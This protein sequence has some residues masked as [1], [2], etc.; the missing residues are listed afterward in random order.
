M[1]TRPELIFA[2]EPTGN[3]DSTLGHRAARATPAPP[4]DG[5]GQTVVMV[6][7]DPR[8][9]AT[10]TGSCSS[11]TA[12]SCDEIDAPTMDGDP[13]HARSGSGLSD[14]MFAPR[15]EEHARQEAAAAS[16]PA[17]AVMLGIAFLAGTLVFTDT[18]KRTFDDLFADIYAD[19][20]TVVR[21]ST[22]ISMEFGWRRPRPHPRVDRGRRS[23]DV[24]GVADAAR[25]RAGLRP[26][27]RRRRRRH[28]QPRPGRP[29]VRH[30][31]RRRRAEPVAAHRGQPRA[32]PGR[33]RR[34]QGQRR[35]GRPRRSATR[36]PCS[37]RPVRTHSRSS[38]P[39]GSARS[40]R[41]A[42]PASPIFDLA[43]AQQVLLGATGE[44]DAVMVDAADGVDR[45]RR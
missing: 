17:L 39:P 26:N 16:A 4:V 15:P 44:L 35:Q 3:L 38:A 2:D 8:R 6:T 28:R 18:I 32:R 40:T 36:S 27:R 23:R 34:R 29:D 10:P 31:L 14:A 42:A 19:T 22:S 11:P 33:A 20:D 25:A 21:S 13:R 7:H 5:F 45:G 1:V 24:D 43:T 9:R 12:A 41:P 30:E 37:P